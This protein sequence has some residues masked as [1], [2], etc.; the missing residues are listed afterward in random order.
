MVT[1]QPESKS[2]AQIVEELLWKLGTEKPECRG[3]VANLVSALRQEVTGIIDHPNK[4]HMARNLRAARQKAKMTQ[5]E[6]AVKTGVSPAFVSQIE[7]GERVLSKGR[8]Q[9][10]A[11]ALGVT[12]SELLM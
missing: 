8:I 4:Q 3:I 1:K 11:K 10:F 9:S 2:P 5:K 12:A 6:L 7:N